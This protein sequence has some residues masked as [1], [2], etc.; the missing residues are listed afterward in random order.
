LRQIE[1]MAEGYEAL[2]SAHEQLNNV[3]FMRVWRA[4]RRGLG[5]SP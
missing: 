5:M 4:L 3:W 1:E 2:R